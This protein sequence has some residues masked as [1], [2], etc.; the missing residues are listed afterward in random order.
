MD[1]RDYIK[2]LDFDSDTFQDAKRDMNF[3][4]QRLLGNMVEKQSNEGS[5]TIK[6]DVEMVSEFIP[7]YDPNIEG[8]SREC[9]KPK[10]KHKV[11]S[12]VK[13]NDE[14]SGNYDSEMEM[15]LDEDT[16]IWELRPVM[17]TAQRTIFDADF[18]EA[19]CPEEEEGQKGLP[20][21]GGY[22]ALPAP[23]EEKDISDE[24]MGDDGYGYEENDE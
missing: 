8:E 1:E 23:E 24:L 6:I 4:L 17:N 20:G 5:M 10:F 7:N 11:T 3:V 2:K 15:F 19:E 16:G 13:I 9:R 14:K 21:E 18:Q 22:M 12:V